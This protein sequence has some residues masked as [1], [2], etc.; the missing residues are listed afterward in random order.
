MNS[1]NIQEAEYQFYTNTSRKGIQVGKKEL[2][3]LF[4]DDIT[5][6]VEI[7]WNL[8]G[9]LLELISKF[10]KFVV[11]KISIHKNINFYVLATNTLQ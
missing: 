11:V 5:N 2:N 3:L 4:A 1:I 10:S 8:Q 6:F 9:K 7:Q